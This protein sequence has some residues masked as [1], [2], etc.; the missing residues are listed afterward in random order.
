MTVI[1]VSRQLGSHGGEIS[2][3]AAEAL[4]LRFVDREIIRQAA[5]EAG[6]PEVAL[7]E[8]EYEGQRSLI[9]RILNSMKAMPPIPPTPEASLREPAA[10]IP[11]PFGGILSPAIPP[12]AATMDD[13]VRMVGMVIRDLAKSGDVLIL[14]RGSQV[15]LR[16]FPRAFHLQV[17]A[18]FEQRV[19]TIMEREGLGP[20]EAITR[21]KA[22][23]RTRR[24]FLRRYHRVEW[25][26]PTLYH[27]V[28]NTGKIPIPV[29]V[30]L[31]V[32]AQGYDGPSNRTAR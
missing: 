31:V 13:Y 29:A 10:S 6:V 21:V 11:L 19:E 28:I 24:E 16:D 8:M 26:D 7:Q 14:G 18:P 22:S 4:G 9:E 20:R 5:Q 30:E 12:F 3:R 17:V 15:L 25:L 32:A 23:D 27:L 1:T 2:A